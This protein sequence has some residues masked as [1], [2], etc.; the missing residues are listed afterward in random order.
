VARLEKYK[1]AERLPDIRRPQVVADTAVGA[2]TT[3]FGRQVRRSAGR[4]AQLGQLLKDRQAQVDT[5]ETYRAVQRADAGLRRREE[6]ALQSLP[7]G[8]NGFTEAM[9]GHLETETRVVA[10]AFPEHLEA[11]IQKELAGWHDAYSTRFAAVEHRERQ[12]YFRDGI[13]EIA[14]A[15]ITRVRDRPEAVDETLSSFKRLV[16]AS[17][18]AKEERARL[19]QTGKDAI[20]EA[21]ASTLPAGYRLLLLRAAGAEEDSISVSERPLPE[22]LE[23]VKQLPGHK[24]ARLSAEA[25]DAFAVSIVDE[26]DRI[27][28]QI[29]AQA[30]GF[31][32]EEIERSPVLS[33]ERKAELRLRLKN[34][35]ARED[36]DLAALDWATSVIA[37]DPYSAADGKRADRAFHRMTGTGADPEAV[38]RS[39]LRTKKLLPPAYAAGL[40]GDL[41]STDAGTVGRAQE[42]LQDLFLLEPAAIRSGRQGAALKDARTKWRIL[43]DLKGMKAGDAARHLAAANDPDRRAELEQTFRTQALP[44]RVVDAHA[45]LARLA[46][47]LRFREDD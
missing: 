14:E 45:I 8:A 22:E 17:P 40:R 23:R 30:H 35:L 38:A 15:L 11:R 12:R 9:L 32:P 26:D 33:T 5:L 34:E 10:Q 18:L 37:A 46:S 25:R 41:D 1:G 4:A 2:A 29:A 44:A 24:L 31:D 27:S 21:W 7:P 16:D 19:L 20:R 47:H 13:A 42:R 6:E 39:L 28:T 3:D 36:E 43:T